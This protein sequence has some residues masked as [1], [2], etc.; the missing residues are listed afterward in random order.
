MTP[1]TDS[2]LLS[3]GHGSG[4]RLSQELVGSILAPFRNGKR[5]EELEDCALLNGDTGVTMDGFT[6]SPRRFP[7][8][9][10]GRLAVCGSANDLTVRGVRAE[11]LCLGIIAEEGL[12]EEELLYHTGEAAEVCR[13]EGITLVAGDTKV[14]PRGTVDGL[15]MTTTA[16]GTRVT[17]GI[18]GIRQLHTG[19][20]ILL[21][22]APGRHGATIAATRYNLRAP[23]LESDC[24][25]LRPVL[26]PLM[27]LPGLHCMR[28]CTRGGVGTV[29]CEWAEGARA[30]IEI[31][32]RE[33]PAD[34]GVRS[35]AD[36]LGFDPLYLA[37]EGTA[38][39]AVAPEQA[40]EALR[41]LRRHPL[42]KDS[43]M[44][45]RVT[46]DHPGYVGLVTAIGGKRV[47]D[48]PVGEILPRIC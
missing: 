31:T 29:L 35:V 42:G 46:A 45:G 39:V 8:S 44:I 11:H 21:T 38:A 17:D 37:C 6:V 34:E 4:G 3:L 33:I 25:P 18:L 43:A 7:G 26:E 20:A 22:G 32:E 12:P 10:L 23:S 14:V 13:A 28:D 27:D 16:V 5:E 48:M 2:G 41:R 15:Y 40:G 1:G 30:G 47:V 19:D 9:C 36:L 24:A